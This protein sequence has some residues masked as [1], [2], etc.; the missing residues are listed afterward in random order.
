MNTNLKKVVFIILCGVVILTTFSL[1]F[2][3][4]QKKKLQQDIAD[5]LRTL[6]EQ[7]FKTEL[8][9]FDFKADDAMRART[10]VLKDNYDPL[11]KGGL[12]PGLKPLPLVN[13]DT[14]SVVWKQDGIR[15]GRRNNMWDDLRH[16]LGFVRQPVEAVRAAVL[17]GPL[18]FDRH[19]SLTNRFQRDYHF[20]L[21]IL[22]AAFSDHIMLALHDGQPDVAWT[23]LLAMTRLVT[24]W[25]PKSDWFEM[26]HSSE[27][28]DTAFVDT[29]QA[30]QF[31]DWP[32]EKLA[33]LQ[34]EWE[35]V[36]F[37]SNIADDV[38][39]LRVCLA[40]V[41]QQW[42]QESPLNGISF[43][44]F[45]NDLIHDRPSAH[46]QIVET[47][48]RINSYGNAALAD[49]KTLLPYFHDREL[50]L[51]EAVRK[52]TWMEMRA[53]PGVTNVL[54]CPSV[55]ANMQNN[56]YYYSEGQI[57][58]MAQM[59]EAEAERRVA[60]TAIA[61]ERYRGKYGTY[62]PTLVPLA[63]EFLKTVPLDF[64]DGKPLRY[65]LTDDGYFVLYSIRKDGVDDGGKLTPP[66][67][68]HFPRSMGDRSVTLGDMDII[69]LRPISP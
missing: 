1:L 48:N 31:K 40:A 27:L 2:Q 11:L 44:R 7:G 26:C 35:S 17:S 55:S 62:P 3:S 16:E 68:Y 4:C 50:E 41:C 57:L 22:A 49:E 51:R 67:S 10:T 8:A 12:L 36:N 61:L 63:P 39:R 19:L 13:N 6:R 20:E 64:I 56:L 34:R 45:A 53:L 47:F 9:D 21:D 43:S 5:L 69:W 33:V 46:E 25:E 23:N 28:I 38:A 14:A 59:A 52:P 66:N 42:S 29:W 30:L 32:D 37:S 18:G 54:P 24:A 65:R 60:I 58:V 15:P